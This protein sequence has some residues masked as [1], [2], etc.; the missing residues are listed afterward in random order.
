MKTAEQQVALMLVGV[1]D[2]L[3]RNRTQLANTIR[4]YAAEFGL[5]AAKG[6]AHLV[7]LLER[8]Q[9]DEG[10]PALARELFASQAKEYEHLQAQLARSTPSSRRGI[11]RTN[12]AAVSPRSRALD[13]SVPCC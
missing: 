12:A 7:P 13:R 10:L 3:I 2:R 9:A 1:R 4:G 5:T 8:I 11:G 6:I